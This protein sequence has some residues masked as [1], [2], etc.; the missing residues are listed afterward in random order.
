MKKLLIVVMVLLTA[1]LQQQNRKNLYGFWQG[2]H[3]EDDTRKFYIRFY[4]NND[5]L[6]AHGYWTHHGFYDS[7]FDIDSVYFSE[8]EIHFYVPMWG[9]HYLGKFTGQS[10]ISGGFC[11]PGE[12]FDS[13]SLTKNDTIRSFLTD[14]LPGSQNPGFRYTWQAPRATNDNLECTTQLS[15]GEM[16]FVDSL[17][18]E[19][20]EG[21][22][23]RIN[24]ILL[25]RNH[26]LFCEEYFWGYQAEDLHPL[27]SATK[28]IT[29]L[30]I[31]I[32]IDQGKINGTEEKIADIFPEIRHQQAEI[33][34]QITLQH[35][36]TMTSGY[37]CKDD[38][39]TQND[40]RISFCLNRKIIHEPGKVFQYDGGNTEILGAVIHRKTGMFADEFA[41]KYLFTPLNISCYQWSDYR[42]NGY[43]LMSGALH[44]RP[45][46][47]LKIGELVLN[48][49][50]CNEQQ[51][52]SKE[53]ID[54]SATT[55]VKTGIDNDNY[56]YL[57]WNISL[58]SKEKEYRCI[59]ANGWGSQFIYIIPDLN[60]VMVTTGHNYEQDSW[61]ITSGLGKYIYLLDEDATAASF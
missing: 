55:A 27:E 1:C 36:L 41:S 47:M 17:L 48:K 59:W 51:I 52:V 43:P 53:W 4:E 45:R 24:S 18:S 49:G 29:S 30:L 61:A 19:I 31:G 9:C 42:Q 34:R 56:S 26:Q 50:R 39:L 32:A 58:E 11:C 28:S 5:S 3:P 25:A 38:E 46:D 20:V 21:K 7:A 8:N 15:H 2:P 33:F 54:A 23:G 14:I 40:D 35:L 10:I 57:W 22:Y 13:V 37:E 44:L 12:P 60:V 16:L 6:S